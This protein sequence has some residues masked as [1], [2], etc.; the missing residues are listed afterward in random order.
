M[1]LQF[2]PGNQL[3]AAELGHAAGHHLQWAVVTQVVLHGVSGYRSRRAAPG[4][5][6]GE[7]ETGI[8]V[9]L[10]VAAGHALVAILALFGSTG[11]LGPMAL[12]FGYWDYLA[13]HVTHALHVRA[14]LEVGGLVA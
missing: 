11:A 5:D 13:A 2:P 10:Q 8:V 1:T 12:A 3:L 14:A 9:L 6:L 7:L 4:A